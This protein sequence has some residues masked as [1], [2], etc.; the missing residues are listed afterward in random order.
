LP[1]TILPCLRIDGRI[2]APAQVT[3]RMCDFGDLIYTFLLRPEKLYAKL[4]ESAKHTPAPTNNAEA[5][6]KEKGA[7]EAL[8]SFIP[9]QKVYFCRV[10]KFVQGGEKCRSTYACYE[11]LRAYLEEEVEVEEG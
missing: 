8:M 1:R 5:I 11:G 6:I 4:P 3:R 7:V 2:V 9:N 10:C